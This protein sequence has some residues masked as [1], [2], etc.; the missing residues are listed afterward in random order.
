[1]W[2]ALW[3]AE[4]GCTAAVNVLR[5]LVV[6]QDAELHVVLVLPWMVMKALLC[7]LAHP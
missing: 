3:P 5:K 7:A 2:L 6:L 1:M 4:S